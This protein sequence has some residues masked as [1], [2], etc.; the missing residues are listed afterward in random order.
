MHLFSSIKNS[1]PSPIPYEEI[2]QSA[3]IS[4]DIAESIN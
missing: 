3:K 2:L 1:E 4:I